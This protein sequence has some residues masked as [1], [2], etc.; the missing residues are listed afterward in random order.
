MS[1]SVPLCVRV[2]AAVCVFGRVSAFV[3]LPVCVTVCVSASVGAC[4]GWCVCVSV[5]QC[6]VE[7]GHGLVGPGGRR[8]LGLSCPHTVCQRCHCPPRENAH[9]P[10]LAR[11]AT[12]ER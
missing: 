2:L 10:S 7:H 5:C 8:G 12:R 1:V 6:A 11:S 4:Q 3:C 9:R